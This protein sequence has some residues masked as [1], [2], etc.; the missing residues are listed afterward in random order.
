MS[1]LAWLSFMGGNGSINS[2][3]GHERYAFMNL[4]DVA[5]I[6]TTEEIGFNT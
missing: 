5:G 2:L 1:H 3:S 6:V 4:D